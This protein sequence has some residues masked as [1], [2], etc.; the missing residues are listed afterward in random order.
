MQEFR[1]I[2]QI[3]VQVLWLSYGGVGISE[4]NYKQ[5]TLLLM[6]EDSRTGMKDFKLRAMLLQSDDI[7]T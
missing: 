4:K 5:K 7:L 6:K 3:Y 2:V 1:R